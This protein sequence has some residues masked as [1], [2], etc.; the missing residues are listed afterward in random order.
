MITI[1]ILNLQGDV[2]EHQIITQKAFKDMNIE[3]TTKLVN[4]LND[5]EGCDALIISGGESSTIGMHLEKTGLLN[6]IKESKIPVLGTCAG[7][8]LLSSKTKRDQILLEL[9]DVEVKRN[10]FG[11]QRMSFEAEID[12]D[13]EKYPGIFIRAPY[14]ESVPDDIEVLSTY[15][16]KIIAIKKDQYMAIAFHPELTDN[17][18]IH[19]RFIQEVQRCVE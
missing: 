16:D 17:T 14:I 8:V 9:L 2:E 5:I 15:D 11:R 13:G 3:G 1:G 12:F 7:L 10:G 18:L 19:Q 6:Y 4:I